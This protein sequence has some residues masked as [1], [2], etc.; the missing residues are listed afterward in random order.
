MT[1]L[2]I[3]TFWLLAWW[4][5]RNLV[6]QLPLAWSRF[7]APVLFTVTL[8]ILWEALVNYFNVSVVVLPAPSDIWLAFKQHHAM[9]MS[10]VL[11]TVGKGAMPGLL[12]GG[13]SAIVIAVFIERSEFLARG[14]LPL[15][16]FI[17]ALPIVGIAPIAVAWFGFGWQ[18]KAAVVFALVFFP[19]L[20][21]TVNGLRQVDPTH[22]DM[23][24]TL[25][26][27]EWQDLIHLRFISAL[28]FIFNGLKLGVCLA[29]IGAV[30]SE[31]FGSPTVGVGFRIS[32]SVG[33]LAIDLVWA[34]IFA[35][36]AT[37]AA[38]Y[39]A[40]VML[41]KHMTFWSTAKQN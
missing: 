1:L 21:N 10:D 27:N 28:P 33:I 18:S 15:A 12:L 4:L 9:I 17:A 6:Q 40:F 23:F 7:T 26:S 35:I 25:S 31:Y 19:I 24:K 37:G 41:E 22:Q 32:T 34:E 38:V 39:V 8:F 11:H 20:L 29:M 5:N 16:S 3:L 2:L 36:A 14:V 30:I 13:L